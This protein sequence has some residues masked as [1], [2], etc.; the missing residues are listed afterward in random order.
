MQMNNEICHSE[1]SEESP[2]KDSS[3]QAPRNDRINLSQA[4]AFLLQHDDY[5]ILTH[6][7]PDGDTVGSAAAL[8]RALR[9]LGKTAWIYENPQFTPKFAPYLN[10]LVGAVTGHPQK[11]PL[12]AGEG[13]RAAVE[14]LPPSG[15]APIIVSVDIASKTLFPFGMED[16]AVDLAIDH[17]GTNAGF[18]ARTFV[19][20][21]RAACGEIIWSL[22]K[23]LDVS[24]DKAIAEAIYVAVSTDTGCF[25][26]SNV[27]AGTLRVAADC[28]ACGAE[29]YPI[30]RAMFEIKSWAR[31][32]LEGYLVQTMEFFRDGL[33][34]VCAIP[35]EIMQSYGLT[36]DDV[37]SISAFPRNIEG[38]KIGVLL[39]QVEGGAGKISV[40]TSP[41]YDASAICARMG[42]GGHAAAAGATVP[43]G[44]TA[45]KA[46]VLK[47]IDEEMKPLL[48]R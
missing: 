16:A 1:R 39:R 42:G 47:A 31:L 11:P 7:R 30:N 27:T 33:V 5:L 19:D 29:I 10:G 26:Y 41:Q 8:C 22:L 18:A 14:G 44:I 4:A 23:L 45:A 20:A 28:V 34:A 2:A 3:S 24:P 6:R 12:L 13:D 9:S 46:A 17:H 38:V 32:R 37:D 48:R 21:D 36:E 40:R 43:G 35:E 25:R 15:T